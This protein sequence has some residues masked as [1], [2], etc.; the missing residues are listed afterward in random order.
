[1]S[2]GSIDMDIKVCI[3]NE[4]PCHPPGHELDSASMLLVKLP[5]PL[6]AAP[7]LPLLSLLT[8]ALKQAC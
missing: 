3:L 8:S 5:L 1:M 6:A 4:A 2:T 7:L